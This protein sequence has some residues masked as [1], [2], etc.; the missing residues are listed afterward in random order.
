MAD[1]DPTDASVRE[2][3]A[4]RHL[5]TLTTLRSDGSPHVAPVGVTYEESSGL[6]RVIASGRS[7]KVAN[8]ERAGP[9]ARVAACFVDG[10]RW[11]SVEGTATVRRDPDAVAEA[12]RHYARRYR[13]PRPNAERVAIEIMVTRM[14]GHA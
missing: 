11:V 2:L 8:I 3:W 1:L 5:A 7:V 10:R 9:G 6:A 14:M 4:A 12:V 13:E